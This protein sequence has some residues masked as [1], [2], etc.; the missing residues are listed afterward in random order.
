M[1]PC[2]WIIVF[3]EKYLMYFLYFTVLTV[4]VCEMCSIKLVTLC[5]VININDYKNAT[6][7]AMVFTIIKKKIYVDVFGPHQNLKKA[8]ERHWITF[9]MCIS[10]SA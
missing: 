1:T 2:G 5:A 8:S 3:V 9:L 6:E 10:F 7:C 4:S